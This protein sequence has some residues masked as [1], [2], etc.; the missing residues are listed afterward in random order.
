MWFHTR[1]FY[2]DYTP[3]ASNRA[4][5]IVKMAR[6]VLIFHC[7][8]QD[9][10]KR[11]LDRLANYP[12]V[13]LVVVSKLQPLEAIM[14]AYRLGV[15]HFGENR[16]SEALEKIEKAPHD[17]QWHFIGKLQRNKVAKIIGKCALIHSVDSFELAQKISEESVK[18]NCV[19]S[20]LLE[21][22]TSSEKSKNGLSPEGWKGTFEK[23]LDLSHIK[24]EGLMTMAPLTHDEALIHKTFAALKRLQLDLRRSGCEL[25]ILSMG[26]SQ[27]YEIALAEG[28]TLVRIGSAIFK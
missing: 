2:P 11:I 21:A 18:K 28:S 1:Q 27:D 14:E 19:S 23:L 20:I 4:N 6:F 10:L 15:R 12:G 16:V 13:C 8:M 26:M 24:I 9:N 7:M 22:N 3:I 17:I 5:K 25:T